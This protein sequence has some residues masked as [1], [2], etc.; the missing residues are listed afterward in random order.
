MFER[1]A[2][3]E[4]VLSES[5]AQSA[6]YRKIKAW[7]EGRLAELRAMNDSPT[8]D[9]RATALLRGQIRELKNLAAL[10]KPVPPV[11]ADDSKE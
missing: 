3:T 1:K 9:E 7:A 10:D 5:E 4:P 11:E 2:K 6:L 8:R